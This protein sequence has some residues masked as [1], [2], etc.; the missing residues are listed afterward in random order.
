[1]THVIISQLISKTL[2]YSGDPF[3]YIINQS[4]NYSG[5]SRRDGRQVVILFKG[6]IPGPTLQHQV[7][8]VTRFQTAKVE[9]RLQGRLVHLLVKFPLRQGIQG[10]W[11]SGDEYR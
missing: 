5:E 3:R 4:L 7:G 11:L 8:H 1:M 9:S 6:W 10:E 2:I